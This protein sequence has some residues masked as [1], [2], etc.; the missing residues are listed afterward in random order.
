MIN[1]RPATSADLELLKHWDEQPQVIAADPND[2]WH[3]EIEL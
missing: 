1:L 3:W 2:D